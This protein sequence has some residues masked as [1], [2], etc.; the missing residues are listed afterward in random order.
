M[1]DKVTIQAI[2]KELERARYENG[3]R[4]Q[5]INRAVGEELQAAR[6]RLGWTRNQLVQCVQINM[7]VNTYA[8]Y[9]QGVR[10][11]SITRLVELCDTLEIAAPD[12]L[13]RALQRIAR[14]TFPRITS[15]PDV[16]GGAPCIDG[17][18]IPVSTIISSF[19]DGMSTADIVASYPDLTTE[20]VAEALR[21]AARRTAQPS[22]ATT[23]SLHLPCTAIDGSD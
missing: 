23:P 18:N 11:C 13:N 16:M 4:N 17:L 22:P 8:C 5:A 7:P 1:D 14:I 19:A 3:D 15:D 12:L 10:S 21:Y 6:N 9:E 2:G 20:D